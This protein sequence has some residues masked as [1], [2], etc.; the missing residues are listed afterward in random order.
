MLTVHFFFCFKETIEVQCVKWKQLKDSVKNDFR[1]FASLCDPIYLEN[2]R[3]RVR[4]SEVKWK[5]V[6]TKLQNMMKYLQ[7]SI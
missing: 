1:A 6:T 5:R 4:D 2:L 7:V 3:D